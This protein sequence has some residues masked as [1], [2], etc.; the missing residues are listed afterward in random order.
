MHAVAPSALLGAS[1]ISALGAFVIMY[2]VSG[3]LPIGLSFAIIASGVPI[4]VVRRRARVRRRLARELWPEAVDHL[5]S[6][7][8]A[9]LSLPA[10]L[11]QLAERGP[12]EL[13]PAF[14]S[15]SEDYR[16]TGKFLPS[17]DRLKARMA[18]PVAD[19]II[20]S[21]RVTRQVGGSDLGQTLRTLTEFLR[22]E[23][24]TRSELEA[25]QSWTVNGARLAVAAPWIVLGL[26]STRPEA[27]IAYNSVGGAA[28]LA[29][30]GVAS[31]AAYALMVRIGRL[32]E[33]PRVL[34]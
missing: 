32:R 20:E 21:L 22:Q 28:V 27:V 8:R 11:S 1:L 13:R 26:L 16:C 17:L 5:V 9:G 29:S 7:V 4:A 15:F 6:G 19:R 3:A 24:Q 23:A 30:G 34:A 12:E 31:A 25:R 33:E 14:A 10:A 18:D 2:V